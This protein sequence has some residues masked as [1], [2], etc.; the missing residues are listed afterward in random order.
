MKELRKKTSFPYFFFVF[1]EFL[2]GCPI[3]LSFFP[4]G[5]EKEKS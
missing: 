5:K 2:P 4:K 3:L 1:N